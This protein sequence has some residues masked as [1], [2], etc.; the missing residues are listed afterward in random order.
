MYIYIY[1]C[2][3]IDITISISPVDFELSGQKHQNQ[4]TFSPKKQNFPEGCFLIG[5]D[6]PCWLI[7]SD[8]PQVV[9]PNIFVD[10]GVDQ[11]GLLIIWYELN[12]MPYAHFQTS[13]YRFLYLDVFGVFSFV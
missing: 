13:S 11:S 4:I 7:G 9:L 5:S 12:I 1:M 3:C 2:V 6:H 8:Q 10:L